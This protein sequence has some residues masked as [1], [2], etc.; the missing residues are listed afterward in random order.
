MVQDAVLENGFHYDR[1]RIGGSG[2][3]S[4]LWPTIVAN[5]LDVPVERTRT[6]DAALVG[7]A[8]LGFTALGTYDDLADASDAMVAMGK[9]FPPTDDLVETYRRGYDF[10]GDLVEEMGDLY[11]RHVDTFG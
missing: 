10:F 7:E 5:A 6:P 8:M 9:S 1:M 2:A 11:Q 3:R 4:A